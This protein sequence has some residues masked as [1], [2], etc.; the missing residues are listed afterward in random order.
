[1]AL[2]KVG[3]WWYFTRKSSASY[4]AKVIGQTSD[5]ITDCLYSV[6]VV[7]SGVKGKEE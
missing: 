5:T 2:S 1:M 6:Q 3:I 7:P 4:M